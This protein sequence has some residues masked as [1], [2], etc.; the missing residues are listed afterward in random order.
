MSTSKVVIR[1]DELG[2][3]ADLVNN[4][5]Q[6]LANQDNTFSNIDVM[7]AHVKE[8]RMAQDIADRLYKAKNGRSMK[9][10]IN[11][12]NTNITTGAPNE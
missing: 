5:L 1:Q 9:E 3:V 6:L 2:F 10:A 12:T 11:E 7:E 8:Y 4:K